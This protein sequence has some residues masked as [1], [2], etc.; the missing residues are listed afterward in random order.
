[1][2]FVFPVI[3]RGIS[4]MITR[5]ARQETSHVYHNKLYLN[6]IDDGSSKNPYMLSKEYASAIMDFLIAKEIVMKDEE[7][8]RN[9][10]GITL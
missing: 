2:R 10:K 3:A 7:Q 1:M 5:V 8:P 9:E 6:C 4:R